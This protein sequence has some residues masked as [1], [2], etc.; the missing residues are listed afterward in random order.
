MGYSPLEAKGYDLP[1]Y[2]VE[3]NL[4]PLVVIASV[5]IYF[6]KRKIF[7]TVETCALV[8]LIKALIAVFPLPQLLTLP[9]EKVIIRTSTGVN[10]N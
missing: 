9:Y 8:L 1:F 2:R 6:N 3:V 10:V 5:T 7:A 4:T